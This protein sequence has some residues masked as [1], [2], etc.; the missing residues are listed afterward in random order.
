MLQ[1][2]SGVK[3]NK[4][5]S[6]SISDRSRGVELRKLIIIILLLTVGL[7]MGCSRGKNLESFQ[8]LVYSVESNRVLVVQGI[9]SVDVPYDEWFGA[10]KNAIW[11]TVNKN[12][13]IRNTAGRKTNINGI[14]AGQEI[15]VLFS[16]AVAKSYP[17]QAQ[18]EK[19]N[20]FTDK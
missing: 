10:G 5:Q 19:I 7:A 6:G 18:A 16:G 12:T 1:L 15:E 13:V 11:F 17:G 2:L 8:G 20:I 3:N 9:D 4:E 14:L